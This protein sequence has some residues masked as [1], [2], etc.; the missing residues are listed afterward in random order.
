[1]RDYIAGLIILVA[2]ISVYSGCSLISEKGLRQETRFEPFDTVA[3]VDTDFPY[4]AEFR[5]DQFPMVGDTGILHLTIKSERDMKDSVIFRIHTL[6]PEYVELGIDEIVWPSPRQEEP[7]TAEIPVRFLMGGNYS[8]MFEHLLS[9]GR[10]YNLYLLSVS[11]GIDGKVVYFGKHPTPVSNS[12]GH[13]YT[14]NMEEITVSKRS[15]Y[16]GN[17]KRLGIP[18]DVDLHISPVPKLKQT[19]HVDFTVTTNMHFI[20]DI[21]F[22][23]RFSP[24]VMVA[25]VAPSWEA[26]P[27]LGESYSGSFDIRPRKEGYSVID[28]RVIGKNIYGSKAG[29]SEYKV[30]LWMVFDTTGSLIYLGEKNLLECKFGE[31]DPVRKQLDRAFAFEFGRYRPRIVRSQPDFEKLER[32]KADPADE[33]IYDSP[34]V[35]SVMNEMKKQTLEKQESSPDSNHTGEKK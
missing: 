1:M 19:S 8:I 2:L 15:W 11:F 4:V 25:N 6:P 12:P 34:V 21:Q 20:H 17:N 14:T 9:K 22:E 16:T 10:T 23:W 7:F 29:K 5:F 3:S 27:R 28:F 18:F 32:T 26:R 31:E 35:D 13:F 24:N 33:S 30:P